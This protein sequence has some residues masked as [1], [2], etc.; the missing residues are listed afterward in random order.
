[1]PQFRGSLGGFKRKGA[2]AF[3]PS[4]LLPFQHQYRWTATGVFLQALAAD[5][6]KQLWDLQGW[7]MTKRL[8]KSLHFKLS[9]FENPA[10]PGADPH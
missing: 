8:V 1:M 4:A 7:E 10:R 9:S 3:S 2:A 6:L 5:R